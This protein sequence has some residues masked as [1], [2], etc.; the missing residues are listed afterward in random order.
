MGEERFMSA[1]A[2]A[3]VRKDPDDWVSGDEPMTEAQ[4]SYLQTLSEEAHQPFQ[5][6][7]DLSKAV[8]SKLIDEMRK[9]AG[10]HDGK[11]GGPETRQAVSRDEKTEAVDRDLVH[12]DG[13]SIGSPI[14]PSDL[15]PDH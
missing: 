14:V 1:K 11:N 3:N 10:V 9:K 4:A 5:L 13:G 15:N 12:G 6:R 7:K 8:A 2:N